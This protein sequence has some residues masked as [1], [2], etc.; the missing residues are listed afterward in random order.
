MASP[1][2]YTKNETSAPQRLERRAE[3]KAQRR[4]LGS[5]EVEMNAHGLIAGAAQLGLNNGTVNQHA[6]VRS[7]LY[8]GRVYLDV[9]VSAH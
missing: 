4:L 1:Q 2:R 3:C 5:H 8:I 7:A 6:F 9:Y